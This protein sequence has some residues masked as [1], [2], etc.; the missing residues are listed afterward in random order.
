MNEDLWGYLLSA[1]HA[2]RQPKDDKGQPMAGVNV[3]LPDGIEEFV[4]FVRQEMQRNFPHAMT[5]SGEGLML[6][7]RDGT[8]RLFVE[9]LPEQPSAANSPGISMATPRT[10]RA[11][12]RNYGDRPISQ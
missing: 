2:S 5:Y 4:Q 3:M 9:S 7:M 1:F 11:P 8:E 12:M 10:T 6:R